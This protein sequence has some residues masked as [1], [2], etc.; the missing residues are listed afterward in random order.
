M[1]RRIWFESKMLDLPLLIYNL[2]HAMEEVSKLKLKILWRDSRLPWLIGYGWLHW[3]LKITANGDL[4]ITRTISQSW[5]NI[6]RCLNNL[7]LKLASLQIQYFGHF[8]LKTATNLLMFHFYGSLKVE[9]QFL[10]LITF[11]HSE[12]GQCLLL[13]F[14]HQIIGFVLI[15]NF[16]CMS[17]ILDNLYI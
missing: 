12:D 1:L 5:Q 8:I 7:V 14:I 15:T 4:K 3:I 10:L 9:I 17:L 11:N 16:L 2:G 13:K 6:F